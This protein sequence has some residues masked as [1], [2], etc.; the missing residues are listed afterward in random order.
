M[1]IEVLKSL[2]N[3]VSNSNL[4]AYCVYNGPRPKLS[5]GPS[6]GFPGRR[7]AFYYAESVKKYG[8]MLVDSLLDKAY[9]RAQMF[10][11]GIVGIGFY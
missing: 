5:I 2:V 3:R 7:Q 11:T 4:L 8:H 6:A 10:F 1:H 9:D